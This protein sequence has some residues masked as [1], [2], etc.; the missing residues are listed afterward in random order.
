LDVLGAGVDPIGPDEV[1]AWIDHAMSAP[2][3]GRC[4]Q[5]VT[6]NPEYVMLARRDPRF[7]SAVAGA[8]LVSADGIGVLVSAKLL[9]RSAARGLRRVT[10]LDVCDW[11]A[12]ACASSGTRLFLLGGR[13]GAAEVA[14]RRLSERWPAV[15]I[16]GTWEEGSAGEGD[17]AETLRRIGTTRPEALLVAYGAPGQVLWIERNAGALGDA[18]VRLAIGVG[19]AFDF[20]SGQ[21]PRAPRLVRRTG[22][23]WLYRLGSQP[24]RW[25]RQLVLPRFALLVL[26]SMVQRAVGRGRKPYP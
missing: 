20:L 17:D 21:V 11:V 23:E 4:R 5:L 13:N 16:T 10:G 25:R 14:A 22:F 26:G 8:D 12:A 7:A 6:L 24:W 9:H 15:R 3:G 19:G 2:A 18:G 1:R